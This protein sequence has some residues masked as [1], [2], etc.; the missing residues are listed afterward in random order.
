VEFKVGDRVRLKTSASY[1]PVDSNTVMTIVENDYS[2]YQ[3]KVVY[4]LLN[5]DYFYDSEIE[6]L[7]PLEQLL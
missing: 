6:L 7:T 4:G 2:K 3:Y 1:R 5:T